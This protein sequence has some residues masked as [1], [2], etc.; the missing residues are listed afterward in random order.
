VLPDE[1]LELG[2]KVLVICLCQFPADVNDQNL[3]GVFFTELNGHFELLSFVSGGFIFHVC[4]RRSTLSLVQAHH[5]RQRF[6]AEV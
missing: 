1:S 2:H 3:P 5:L 6:T 4:S